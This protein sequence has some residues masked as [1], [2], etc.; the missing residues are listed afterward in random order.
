[1]KNDLV[2]ICEL[3]GFIL[4]VV[5]VSLFFIGFAQWVSNVGYN[6]GLTSDAAQWTIYII[7][8]FLSVCT[9][10]SVVDRLATKKWWWRE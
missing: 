9:V 8:V 4:G 2:A 10:A 6:A 5:G 7:T 3:V 1:M